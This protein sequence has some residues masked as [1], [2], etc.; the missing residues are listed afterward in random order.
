MPCFLNSN[1]YFFLFCL[2]VFSEICAHCISAPIRELHYIQLAA[3]SIEIVHMR[4]SAR[5][6]LLCCKNREP[7]PLNPQHNNFISKTLFMP[8][9]HCIPSAV[10]AIRMVECDV[11]PRH[12]IAHTFVLAKQPSKH[13]G[14]LES[15]EPVQNIMHPKFAQSARQSIPILLHFDGNAASSLH[16]FPIPQLVQCG[17][18][19]SHHM[20]AGAAYPDREIKAPTRS[21]TT[22]ENK[23]RSPATPK[24]IS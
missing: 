23:P 7:I 5:F 16:S 14:V 6:T 11:F 1:G 17:V 21:H 2:G 12:H 20:A 10:E 3:I 8:T 22:L 9:I 18:C 19:L 13:S 4:T 15:S 24:F